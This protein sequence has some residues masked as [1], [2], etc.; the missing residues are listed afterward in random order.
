MVAN[1]VTY[2]PNPNYNGPDSFTFKVNDGTVDSAPATVTINV[3]P[4][5]DPLQI[6]AIDFVRRTGTSAG[7]SYASPGIAALVKLLNPDGDG[8]ADFD[9]L[10]IRATNLPKNC[11]SNVIPSDDTD[12]TLQK[13][14]KETVPTSDNPDSEDPADSQ[15]EI[16]VVEIGPAAVS[17]AADHDCAVTLKLTAFSMRIDEL[18]STTVSL[19]QGQAICVDSD[20]GVAYACGTNTTAS[21]PKQSQTSRSAS[22]P[23][24][25]IKIA[26]PR[27]R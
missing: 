2:T 13:T 6:Q 19:G 4:V 7:Y 12:V 23:A 16:K 3:T 27:F 5:A 9:L 11:S 1:T 22:A 20:G 24:G 10:T 8:T 14:I 15:G 17:V 21:Q 26:P 25:S 18:Q